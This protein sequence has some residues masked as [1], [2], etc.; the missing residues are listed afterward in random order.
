MPSLILAFHDVG[1]ADNR[2]TI[3]PEQ[4]RDRLQ[5]VRDLGFEFVPLYDLGEL[6][7]IAEPDKKF[8]VVTFDDGRAGCYDHALP[9]LKE[10]G[11]SATFYI[12][13]HFVEGL[14]PPHEAYSKFMTWDQIRELTELGHEVGSHS[15]THRQLNPDT[16]PDTVRDELTLSKI[17][18]EKRTR[19]TCPHFAS[20]YGSGDQILHGLVKQMGYLSDARM[21]ASLNRFTFERPLIRFEPSLTATDAEFR[22]IIRGML[23]AASQPDVDPSVRTFSFVIPARNEGPAMLDTFRHLRTLGP[24]QHIEIILVD[25]ASEPPLNE[26][27][28]LPGDVIYIR[29]DQRIGSASARHMGALR[30][31]RETLIFAD[32]HVCYSKNYLREVN[33]SEVRLGWGIL[34]APTA[35]LYTYADFQTVCTQQTGFRDR[36]YYGWKFVYG[37]QNYVCGGEAKY[38]EAPDTD[39]PFPTV[40]YV[41]AC[42]LA[43]S[44]ELYVDLGGFD[45]CLIESGCWEDLDLAMKVYARG[46]DVRLAQH[47]MCWHLSEGN[48]DTTV[49][50]V[51]NPFASRDF[52][53]YP[54][55]FINLARV[56][57]SNL[58]DAVFNSVYEKVNT[59]ADAPYDKP[60]IEFLENMPGSRSRRV[61]LAHQ[62]NPPSYVLYRITHELGQVKPRK[63]LGH[64]Q[65]ENVPLRIED[66]RKLYLKLLGDHPAPKWGPEQTPELIYATPN[67][68]FPVSDAWLLYAICKTLQPRRVVEIGSGFSTAAMLDA[69]VPPEHI[70]CIAPNHDRLEL[71][72]GER[73]RP[74]MISRRVQDTSLEPFYALRAGDILFVD[75][76]HKLTPESDVAF[77]LTHVLPILQPGVFVHFHDIFYSVVYPSQWGEWDFNESPALAALFANMNPTRF[78]VIA[79]NQCIGMTHA[80]IFPKAFPEFLRNL[81]G[82]LWIEVGS[83]Q[84]LDLKPDS[85]RVEQCRPSEILEMLEDPKTFQFSE[86]WQCNNV[87]RL[88][89]KYLATHGDNWRTPFHRSDFNLDDGFF[90]HEHA[91]GVWMSFEQTYTTVDGPER[92]VNERFLS[93]VYREFA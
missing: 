40:P 12:C 63:P 39:E 53:R 84:L 46:L 18:I 6:K 52:I 47:T 2:W 23:D 60:L 15:L 9:I 82:S 69:G 76:S 49:R 4:L 1:Y 79:F 14:A 88:I 91:N 90:R 64:P 36:V 81:G 85:R 7:Q 33:E 19:R 41:G 57:Y 29:S 74:H 32:A 35:L 70:L 59:D 16:A 3:T 67:D 38:L 8:A 75:S 5:S 20:P 44:R 62:K 45:A 54:G 11:I 73:S 13:P 10:F 26:T 30:A 55:S 17:E 56:L 86:C 51:S 22:Q 72:L 93:E 58:S 27:H 80:D 37:G 92:V 48:Y 25:D 87:F 34:G 28:A 65:W 21:G 83:M 43:I 42:A 66:Q 31:S 50:E 61:H 24:P 77:I 89:C 71:L 78:S 68:W